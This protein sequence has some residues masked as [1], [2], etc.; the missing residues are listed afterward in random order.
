[1]EKTAKME[2]LEATKKEVK[3]GRPAKGSEEAKQKM[4]LVRSKKVKK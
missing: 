4:A 2:K 1:M 3:K